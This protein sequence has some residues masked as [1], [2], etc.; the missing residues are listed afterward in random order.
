MLLSAFVA[1]V[2]GFQVFASGKPEGKEAPQAAASPSAGVAAI[3]G[4]VPDMVN[5][6]ATVADYE[7]A[8]GKKLG[9]LKEAPQL[10][11][12]SKAGKLP[13]LAQ[14]VSEEPMVMVPLESIGKY[15]GR[16]RCAALSPVTGGAE[17][18]TARTQPLLMVA[19]NLQ[20]ISPNV[21]KGW[22][23]N[24]DFSQLT[25]HLRKG[26]KWSDG[27]PF[28]ADDFLFWYEDI[29]ANK[30][31]TTTRPA[32]W[33]PLQ[34]VDKVDETT[35][36][37]RFSQPY[38][39]ILNVLATEARLFL[40]V[41]FAPKHYLSQ[42]HLK[43]NP[44]ANELAKQRGVD[45]WVQL[46]LRQYPN[47]VQERM[48][49]AVPT[50][51]PW[52]MVKVD[53]FGNKYFDRNPYYW[54]VDPEGNQLPYL[55]GQDR[56]LFANLEAVSCKA[57]AGELDYVLQFTTAGNYP[58]YKDNESRGKYKTNMWFDGRGNVL[59]CMRPN[60]NHKDPVMRQ[61]FNDL[62]FRKALSYA[63][64]RDE[65]NEVI[66]RGL[67]TPRGAMVDPDVSFYEPWMGKNFIEFKPDES[68]KLLDEIGLKWD[69]DKK[70][71]LRPDGKPL[72]INIE[73]F[74]LEDKMDVGVEMI[75]QNWEAVGIKVATKSI[76]G[77]LSSQRFAA[78][79]L[80]I[81]IWNMDQTTEIG[82]HARPTYHMPPGNAVLWTQWI[83][84]NGAQGEKP[85]EDVLKYY[86]LAT[87][88]QKYPI[89][90]PKYKEI[91]KQLLTIAANDLWN[92]GVAGI[93]PKPSLV[94]SS[95]KN[96]KRAGSFIYDYRFW[97]IYH[98]EQ[99]YYE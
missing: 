68:R 90:H 17:A 28:T 56:L 75:K 96:V 89:G 5:F 78:G 83:N 23:W 41:P 22:D 93:T 7:K 1:I 58:L 42:F 20:G 8:S 67:A 62:R 84:T 61:L 4:L 94:K 18:S 87:E 72:Q 15:G 39:S 48:D 50:I 65:I 33:R 54:K 9:A 66:W 25:I 35:V 6:F 34:A 24:D 64:N 27:A 14:R 26:M 10:A 86:S 99:W 95:L 91:G 52:T 57:I 29:L 40:E 19:P 13:P 30:D 98:P 55:D 69:A 85:P 82:F 80:D 77:P 73:Y 37:F 36:R 81:Y 47:E 38:P 16:I 88:F 74:I 45:T 63:V 60:L 3:K 70:Y 59:L 79:E 11:E 2:V 71:R 32:S 31:V 97:M 46:L 21:A 51:D 92:I 12:Q 53:Q 44:K 43:Y 49:P 76:D